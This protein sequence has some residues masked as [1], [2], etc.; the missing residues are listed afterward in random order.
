LKSIV[1]LFGFN[2]RFCTIMAN[3]T[4]LPGGHRL[5]GRRRQTRY[6]AHTLVTPLPRKVTHI[7]QSYTKNANRKHNNC[8]Q[9]DRSYLLNYKRPR[10]R[11]LG[12]RSSLTPGNLSNSFYLTV[13]HGEKRSTVIVIF[14]R[15]GLDSSQCTD[16][17]NR[18]D[19]HLPPGII[20]KHCG[21]LLYLAPITLDN[22]T[23][24][25]K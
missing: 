14:P 18:Y 24:K 7:T 8:Y 10:N 21:N 16:K 22:M 4:R 5:R 6:N 15:I 3:W 20:E 2:V 9:S 11:P 23:A 19:C 17:D 1:C 25:W 13:Y 12:F